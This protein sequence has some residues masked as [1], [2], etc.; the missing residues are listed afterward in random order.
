MNV[1]V[2]S[3]E[4]VPYA[5]TGGLADVA[6]ALPKYL[7]KFGVNASL[8]MPLYQKVPQC[9]AKLIKL[10]PT[11]TVPIGEK[12]LAGSFWQGNSPM[13]MAARWVLEEIL[14]R[15]RRRIPSVHLY[16]VGRGSDLIFGNLHDPG[17]TVTGRIPS[18]LPYLYH[19]DVALVPLKF[20]SGTRFKIM[21]A[22]ACGIPVVSTTLGAEGLPVT[23]GRHVLL[24]DEPD[25]F[26]DAIAR[27][28]EE[29]DFARGLADNCRTL[30][31]ACCSIETLENEAKDILQ[32]L[33]H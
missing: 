25:V 30:I 2:V 5:K 15:L 6:G 17:V 4:A 14:P 33:M 24:A 19:A 31:R 23:D 18:V 21:E 16:I 9:G 22:G 28:I 10:E 3:A 29:R 27:L 12:I 32:R 13:E 7:P 26:A 1:M 11:V 20:E 8:V